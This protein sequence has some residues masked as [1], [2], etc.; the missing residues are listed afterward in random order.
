MIQTSHSKFRLDQ[1]GFTLFEVMIAITILA[2]IMV[3]VISVTETSQ[4]TATR[5]I[6]ED[7]EALQIETAMARLEWDF[8]HIY[9]PLYYSH[10]IDPSG[11]NEDQGEVYEQ[12]MSV[13]QN[14]KRF[15]TVSHEGFPIPIFTDEEKSEIIFL[16][17]SNRRKIKNTK[18]SRFTWVRYSLTAPDATDDEELEGKV[19]IREILPNDVFGNEDID[20][21]D[22]KNQTL[23]KGVTKLVFEFWDMKKKKWNDNLKNLA[24]EGGIIRGLRI[25]INYLLPSDPENEL[26][27]ERIFRPMFPYFVPEN[28]YELK[29]QLTNQNSERGGDT[30]E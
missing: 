6:K 22:V 29:K 14:N 16:T 10:P 28:V 2:F 17:M 20:W 23:L 27:S 21:D 12:I 7:R 11:F 5:V 26:Y 25:K 18:Q 19:L 13:Y 15:K 1:K 24:K 8:S 4:N 9:S 30:N 3:S